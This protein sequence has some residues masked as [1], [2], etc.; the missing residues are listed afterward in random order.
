MPQGRPVQPNH[1][2]TDKGYSAFGLVRILAAFLLMASGELVAQKAADQSQAGVEYIAVD[3]TTP[4]DQALERGILASHL[5]EGFRNTVIAIDNPLLLLIKSRPNALLFDNDGN[6]FTGAYRVA[7]SL[8][9]VGPIGLDDTFSAH[10]FGTDERFLFRRLAYVVPVGSYGTRIG[11]SYFDF[12][13]RLAKDFEAFKA[14]GYGNSSSLHALQPI[15]QT[16]AANI[17][18]SYAYER[19]KLD[20]RIDSFGIIVDRTIVSGKFGIVGDFR[21]GTFGG[22][23]NSFGYTITEGHMD[24]GPFLLLVTDLGG[25]RT[26]GRFAKYNYEFRRLRKLTENTS[27]LLSVRGQKVSKNMTSAEKFFLGGAAGV[28]AYPAGE[29]GGDIGHLFQG[30]LRY[31]VPGFKIGSGDLALTA[32][33]DQGYVKINKNNLITP[34]AE[35]QNSRNII[36]YGIG[37]H[38]GNAADFVVR[39]SVAWRAETEAPRSDTA[40]RI[41]RV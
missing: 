7:A 18:L 31:L 30:E 4:I 41:P 5:P 11:A 26:Q 33:Y 13:Y 16:R 19:T 6:R 22:G 8:N 9:L 29:A 12:D 23:L 28:R 37:F 14:H 39:A 38:V 24:I 35:T 34:G 3:V 15:V 21:D 20:D 1:S 17:I 40:K 27:L 25:R 10:A 32:F 2:G 36:G